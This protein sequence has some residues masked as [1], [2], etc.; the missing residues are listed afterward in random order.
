[1]DDELAHLPAPVTN[2]GRVVLAGRG[3]PARLRA[4]DPRALRRRRSG[5]R[6]ELPRQGLPRSLSPGESAEVELRVP[7]PAVNGQRELGIDAVREGIAW[8]ADYGSSP[9]VVQ[10]PNGT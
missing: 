6:I 10:L 1:M 5:G 4:R 2:A 7:G 9:L 3:R 8:F